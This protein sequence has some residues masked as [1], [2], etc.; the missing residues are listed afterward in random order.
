MIKIELTRSQAASMCDF[1][2]AEFIN[3]IWTDL[4]LRDAEYVQGIKAVYDK[5]QEVSKNEG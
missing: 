2:E 3:G 1:L 5:L 4:D